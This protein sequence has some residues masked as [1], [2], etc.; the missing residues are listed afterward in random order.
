MIR[1]GVRNLLTDVPGIRIGNAEDHSVRSGVTVVLP[2]ATAVCA[3]DVRGGAPG[4]R[5][6]DLLRPGCLIEQAHAVVLSGGSAFGLAAADGVM[7][8]L[9]AHGQ[10]FR[11]ADARIPI[12]PAAI[13]FDLHN[14]GD[15]GWGEEPP[16][17][18]LGRLAC[19]RRSFIS[20]MSCADRGPRSG[21]R[22]RVDASAVRFTN[23]ADSNA[24][25]KSDAAAPNCHCRI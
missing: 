22:L 3:V 10:G 7:A 25:D 2:E 11:A 13:L 12:V 8:W 9:A 6:T 16:Y 14:G 23:A 1:P 17:R 21:T 24:Y 4:T 15:K 18:R 19:E 20:G 5:E